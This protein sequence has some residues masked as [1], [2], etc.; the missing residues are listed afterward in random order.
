[1]LNHAYFESFLSF[2]AG[3]IS[4]CKLCL[5]PVEIIASGDGG[6][7]VFSLV[8]RVCIII[9]D[10]ILTKDFHLSHFKAQS[11]EFL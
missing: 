4:L 6:S 11:S 2:K 3:N 1:M 10:Y 7:Q 9:L 5:F 8:P